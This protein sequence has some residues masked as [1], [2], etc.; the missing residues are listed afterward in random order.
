[1]SN[2]GR[3]N[4]VAF[5]NH[6]EATQVVKA[7]IPEV[8][9]CLPTQNVDKRASFCKRPQDTIGNAGR[10]NWNTKTKNLICTKPIQFVMDN[11]G[12][13]NFMALTTFTKC[14]VA[15]ILRKAKYAHL[16]LWSA[17]H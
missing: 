6:K 2:D 12:R 9:K 1:M 10:R 16:K 4:S 8:I 7:E 3:R 14:H 17:E 11:D 13:R 15:I 5:E